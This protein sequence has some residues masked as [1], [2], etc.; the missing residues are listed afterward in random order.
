MP[1]I[2]KLTSKHASIPVNE[3]ATERLVKSSERVR[4]L[5]EVFTPSAIVLDI[6]NLLPEE[7]WQPHPSKTFL[8][9][10]CGDGNFLVAI[11]AKKLDA[12]SIGTSSDAFNQSINTNHTLAL[13]ALASIY[14][15]D[16]SP[17]NIIGGTPGHEIGARERLLTLFTDWF[18]DL[19]CEKLEDDDPIMLSAKW[20]V[21]QNILVGNM[22]PFEANGQPSGRSNIPLI[23]Y[24]WNIEAAKVSISSTTLGDVMESAE[25][26][27]GEAV[28]LFGAT[29]AKH[30]WTGKIEDLHEV[31][32]EQST[33]R[34]GRKG[35]KRDL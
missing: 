6:L 18:A 31:A 3:T 2:E 12:I 7:A 21:T 23:E 8:E 20:I 35:G 32:T 16:I 29:P 30:L 5:G 28:S 14:G 1:K 9:P 4:D 10:A 22:L 25:V 11:L 26:E 17:D 24:D 33:T 34:H 13:E 19:L 27:I 15:V